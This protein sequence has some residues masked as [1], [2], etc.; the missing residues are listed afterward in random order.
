MKKTT[1][2]KKAK[3]MSRESW[4]RVMCIFLAFLMILPL[5]ASAFGM[6]M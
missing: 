4:F 5:I 1:K 6:M 3:R 2:L